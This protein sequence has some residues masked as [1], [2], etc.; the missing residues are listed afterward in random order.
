MAPYPSAL[1]DLTG[2]QALIDLLHTDQ[3]TVLGPTVRDGVI[4]HDEIRSVDDLPRGIGDEQ[5][6]A[7][8]R[9][10]TRDD[11]AL[12]GYAVGA[13]SWKRLLF[14]ARELLQRST[15]TD[16]EDEPAS[17][18][19]EPG[20]Y[21]LLGVRSCDL[22]AVGVHDQ[23]L[24][25]RP[26]VDAHYATRRDDV[27]VIAVG[28]S[29]PAG[30]CF[31][32]SMGTGPAPREGYDLALT[33][34]IDERGHRFVIR[35]GSTRG[36]EL[37]D[38]LPCEPAG[39]D[40]LTAEALVIDNATRHMGRQLQTEGLRDLLYANAE[41]PQWDDVANR[42]LACSNCTLVCPT[43]FCTSIE[44]HA[45]LATGTAE[46]WRVWDSCFTGEFTHLHGGSVR[47]STR[48]RYR[49]WATHK[50]GTWWDQFGTSGCVGCGRCVTWCPAAIDITAEMAALRDNPL[51]PSA[52]H[53]RSED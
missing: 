3:W 20:R 50:L 27:F 42:C 34:L 11:E 19:P 52:A 17:V 43:C 33:E 47:P 15:V 22:A 51:A 2:L 12:F 13:E 45:D 23:V 14:P 6:G 53:G 10:R 30:S 49:Q 31:C 38:R 1:L 32:A 39:D 8:Y 18:M 4:G 7:H 9:L 5:D 25:N 16:A 41:H 29:D 21:A 40:D 24:L 46:R 48:A 28:C 37:L 44:D 26:G 36:A 35:A